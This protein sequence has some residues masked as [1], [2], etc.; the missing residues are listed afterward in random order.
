VGPKKKLYVCVLCL[1]CHSYN[2]IFYNHRCISDPLLSHGHH[3]CRTVH[4]LCNVQT[5]LI[6]GLTQMGKSTDELEAT[7]TS[8]Y[9]N[10]L[11]LFLSLDKSKSILCWRPIFE[12][13]QDWKSV[14]L[15][16]QQMTL[17]ISLRR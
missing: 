17:L 13:F 12:W 16:G 3:F 7:S 14:L 4:T 15:E 11:G 2:G 1:V 10:Q 9:M 6:N 5:L 8:K